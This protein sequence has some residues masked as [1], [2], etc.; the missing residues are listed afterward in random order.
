MTKTRPFIV[1]S[2]AVCV[3]LIALIF[4]KWISQRSATTPAVERVS[5]T[6]GG[7]SSR[8]SS[9]SDTSTAT[10]NT[11]ATKNATEQ[12]HTQTQVP[13]DASALGANTN[14]HSR[15]EE[16][17]L[18]VDRLLKNGFTR[19][20]NGTFVAEGKSL[21]QVKTIIGFDADSS[22]ETP[23]SRLDDDGPIQAALET[24]RVYAIFDSYSLGGN[25]TKA[26]VRINEESDAVVK[27]IDGRQLVKRPSDKK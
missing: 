20:T 8:E 12:A 5:S 26:T 11:G 2:C 1:A 9:R 19:E 6:T 10:A 27:P 4:A 21:E 17:T 25:R 24:R 18:L 13:G 23:I 3:C 16:I 7:G 22:R 14:M 15:K